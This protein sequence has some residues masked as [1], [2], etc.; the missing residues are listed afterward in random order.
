MAAF[1]QVTDHI[2]RL[3]L[4]FPVFGPIV[5]PVAVWLVAHPDG[6]T[7]VDSGPP[8]A[9]NEMVLAIRQAVRGQSLQRVVLTH[10]HYDHGGGLAALRLAWNPALI[11]HRAEGPFVTGEMRYRRQTARRVAFLWGRF[12]L[13]ARP[14]WYSGG[15]PRA[16][17]R[18]RHSRPENGGSF[19]SPTGRTGL[20][21]PPAFARPAHPWPRA[22]GLTRLP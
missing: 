6:W 18:D 12:F 5:V 22:P 10:A 16:S 13:A 11:C 3:E 1:E 19:D 17:A 8:E 9:A 21:P 2:H 7:L 20:R 4:P 15:A 14:P